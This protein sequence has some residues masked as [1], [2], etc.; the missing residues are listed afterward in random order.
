[1]LYANR[2]GSAVYHKN[3][4]WLHVKKSAGITTRAL[5]RPHYVEVDR[6]QMPKNF[7]QARPEEYNDILNNYRVVLGEYQFKRCLFA[8]NHLYPCAWNDL[9]SF[10]FCR[11]PVDRCVSMFYYLFW[12]DSGYLEN[13]AR[14]LRRFVNTKKLVL[15][16]SYAFDLF[17]DHVNE[18]RFSEC[19][20]Q[21]LGLHFA[22]HTAPMWDDVT[23]TK[24]NVLLKSV[25]RL[26]NLAVGINEAFAQCGFE[27]RLTRPCRK[28][29]IN[30]NKKF[31]T[32]NDCQ[33]V[34]IRDIYFKDFEL[35][36]QA[37]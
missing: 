28:M 20:Y 1:M 26:E 23:D 37:R 31:Y 15:K 13:L 32:P 21:P 6:T 17:L 5:L 29:N 22:T 2:S 14:T 35:Y 18:A 25:F 12:K 3:L 34:K 10:A 36:E 24:G 19:I 33:L 4:F 27:K 11:E 16:T 9:Y 7:I 8:K 30:K